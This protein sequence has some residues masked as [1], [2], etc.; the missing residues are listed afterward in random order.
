MCMWLLVTDLL[1][2]LFLSMR[3]CFELQQKQRQFIYDGEVRCST[4]ATTAA[5]IHRALY[6]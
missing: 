6:A 2:I 1:V 5:H 4:A 3:F